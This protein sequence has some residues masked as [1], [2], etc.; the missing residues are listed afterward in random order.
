MAAEDDEKT[1]NTTAADGCLSTVLHRLPPPLLTLVL[2]FLPLPDKLAQL[3][4]IHHSLPPLTPATFSFDSISVTRPL[5]AAWHSS[6]H[7]RHLLS[8]ARAVLSQDSIVVHRP[9]KTDELGWADRMYENSMPLTPSPRSFPAVQ[10]MQ[11]CVESPSDSRPQGVMAAPFDVTGM[12]YAHLRSLH[13]ELHRDDREN[14]RLPLQAAFV[15][16]LLSL[17]S[18]RT[19][20]LSSEKPATFDWA[21]FR[22]LLSLPLTHLDLSSMRVNIICNM[23]TFAQGT[24]GFSLPLQ[25]ITAMWQVLN[26]PQMRTIDESQRV[27]IVSTVLRDYMEDRGGTGEGALE[28]IAVEDVC[29]EEEISC[30]SRL[31]T[32]RSIE[33]TLHKDA[34]V[35]AYDFTSLCRMASSS[36]VNSLSLGSPSLSSSVIVPSA[37]AFPLLR[38]LSVVSAVPTPEGSTATHA[39]DMSN[40]MLQHVDLVSCYSATLVCLKLDGVLVRDSFRPILQAVFSCSQLRRC[41]LDAISRAC[42]LRGYPYKVIQAAAQQSSLLPLPSAAFADSRLTSHCRSTYH[43]TVG[44]SCRGGSERG[45]EGGKSA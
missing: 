42:N 12:E 30:L 17:P 2:H 39:R 19:L 24:V 14:G 13:V 26:F 8:T 6:P 9:E 41:A 11:L 25:P 43:R 15:R 5:L 45:C 34:D 22:L 33:L 23:E 20:Q 35:S 36:V 10:Q 18:L 31:S 29:T 1:I 7:L 28:Q 32:L 37:P 40:I 4:H 27:D 21:S 16:P 44:L 3:T 38:H